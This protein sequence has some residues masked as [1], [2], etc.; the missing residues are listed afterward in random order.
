VAVGGAV[1]GAAGAADACAIAGI[2]DPQPKDRTQESK[3]K[4]PDAEDAKERRRRK[5]DK[6]DFKIRY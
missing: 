6:L 4:R 1:D 3:I 2:E 5:R